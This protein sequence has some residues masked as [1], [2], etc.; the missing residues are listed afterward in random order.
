MTKLF[1][2]KEIR[3]G[4]RR[5]AAS[6]ESVK[7]LIKAGLEVAIESGAGREA[8]FSDE[9]YTSAGATVVASA[10]VGF[11]AAHHIKFGE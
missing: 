7:K 6:P 10:A 2:P 5:V 1:V 9:A 8:G 4:E 3:A 11:Q